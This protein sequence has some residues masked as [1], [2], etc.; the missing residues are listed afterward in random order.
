MD[1]VVQAVLGEGDAGAVGQEEA[2]LGV[3]LRLD[4]VVLVAPSSG[5]QARSNA[6]HNEDVG[7]RNRYAGAV[8]GGDL[9]RDKPN[10]RDGQALLVSDGDGAEGRVTVGDR[11]EVRQLGHDVLGAAAVDDPSVQVRG[12]HE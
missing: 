10:S 9:K 2:T 7:G 1:S 4:A 6:G 3:E 11:G 12:D 5:E 8:G